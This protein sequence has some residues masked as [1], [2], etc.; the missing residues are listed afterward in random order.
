[1]KVACVIP[2]RGGSVRIPRKNIS[3]FH[4]KPM[5]QR[6]IEMARET[7]LFDQIIVSTD[8]AAVEQASNYPWD[9]DIAI[10]R[11]QTDD[12]TRGTQDVARDALTVF[13]QF[14]IACVLYPCAPLLTP[15][16]LIRGYQTLH[17]SHAPFAYSTRAGIDAGGFY[18]GWAYHFLGGTPLL[19]A[20]RCEVENHFDINTPEDWSRAEKRYRELHA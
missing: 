8:H 3:L 19:E 13:K 1:M 18:W 6:A 4:G 16:E 15:Q 14:G 20:A 12:G 17:A 7:R 2:A 11:R 10:H 5:L 9:A